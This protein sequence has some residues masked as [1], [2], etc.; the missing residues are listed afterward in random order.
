MCNKDEFPLNLTPLLIVRR[1]V[2]LVVD[3]GLLLMSLS[4]MKKNTNINVDTRA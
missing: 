4:H 3:R 1:M 2:V